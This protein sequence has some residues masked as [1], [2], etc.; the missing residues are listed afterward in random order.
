MRTGFSWTPPPWSVIAYADTLTGTRARARK[1][2]TY[3]TANARPKKKRDP[4]VPFFGVT[5]SRSNRGNARAAAAAVA[6]HE[7]H[8]ERDQEQEEEHLGD[9]RSRAGDSAEAEECRD[10]RDDEEP[11]C[12]AKHLRLQRLYGNN[13]RAAS[14]VPRRLSRQACV[15]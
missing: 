3:S 7:R 2:T 11:D 1:P 8:D 15:R 5:R 4:R 9:S 6:H 12:P 13:R 10:D 14:A